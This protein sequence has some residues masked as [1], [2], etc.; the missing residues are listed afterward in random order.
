MAL[1]SGSAR[2]SERPHVARVFD[3]SSLVRW[4]AAA[5]RDFYPERPMTVLLFLVLAGA[6]TWHYTRGRD[7]SGI[8]ILAP[9]IKLGGIAFLVGFVGP[10]IFAPDANQGPLLGIFIT[11]PLGF[12]V[13][14][15][16]GI[17]RELS[18]R[19]SAM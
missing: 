4:A 9:A 14:L 19:S 7:I 13:G 16:Y 15:V 17:V 5:R 18:R 8:R 11:G 2:S 6:V 10:I 1:G 12:L 3:A